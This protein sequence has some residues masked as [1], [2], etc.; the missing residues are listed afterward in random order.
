MAH[1]NADIS[2]RDETDFTGRDRR[3]RI[4]R[5]MFPLSGALSAVLCA[6]AH[7]DVGPPRLSP[8][9]GK[10]GRV[11]M[12]RGASGMSVLMI[13]PWLRRSGI[14]AMAALFVSPIPSG[15]RLGCLGS[16][17]AE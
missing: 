8:S 11:V 5:R 12:G 1:P 2:D 4:V 15:H 7:A 6:T 16:G 13:P 17:S 3:I 10:P 14:P 9:A